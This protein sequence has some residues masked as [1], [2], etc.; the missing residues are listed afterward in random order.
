MGQHAFTDRGRCQQPPVIHYQPTS[1]PRR[2]PGGNEGS[3][4]HGQRSRRREHLDSC[5]SENSAARKYRDNG[6]QTCPYECGRKMRETVLDP[7]I[8][9]REGP[10]RFERRSRS[11][12]NKQVLRECSGNFHL[13]ERTCLAVG[14][15]PRVT[16]RPGLRPTSLPGR[17]HAAADAQRDQKAK[18]KDQH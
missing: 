4:N 17:T 10:K 14:S 7:Q 18:S 9:R 13:D 16:V 15:T 5:D 11:Y 2:Q 12:G 8:A 3:R 1:P 6:R